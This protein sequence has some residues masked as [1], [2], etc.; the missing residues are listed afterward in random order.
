MRAGGTQRKML[1]CAVR[2]ADPSATSSPVGFSHSRLQ[3]ARE[4][5]LLRVRSGAYTR[6]SNPFSSS[7]G[8]YQ[9][10]HPSSF[11]FFRVGVLYSCSSVFTRS[12]D[13]TFAS[14]LAYCLLLGATTL[15]SHIVSTF[16]DRST[17]SCFLAR[18]FNLAIGRFFSICFA[19]S[20]SVGGLPIC[21]R[22]S[23]SVSVCWDLLQDEC[24]TNVFLIVSCPPLDRARLCPSSQLNWSTGW[25][26]I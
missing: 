19:F 12:G 1:R 5:A 26:H 2:D 7:F 21:R 13:R 4:G 25:W 14:A 8:Y 18:N 23:L 20:S 22:V 3:G 11:F 9:D 16:F 17:T 24:T 10:S 6:G 15:L